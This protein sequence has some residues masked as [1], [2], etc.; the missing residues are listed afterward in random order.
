MSLACELTDLETVKYFIHDR[1]L[2]IRR[3]GWNVVDCFHTAAIGGKREIMEYINDAPHDVRKLK[4]MLTHNY[5]TALTLAA[6]SA[7][8]E[9]VEFL[10]ERFRF[11]P[12]EYG[13]KF[14]NFT[15]INGSCCRW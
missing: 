1:G 7:D 6:T 15:T 13:N 11:S 8:K 4:E 3:Q 10:I 12:Y 14:Q 2:D 5:K 9:T